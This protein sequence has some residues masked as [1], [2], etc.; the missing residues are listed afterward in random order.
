MTAIG[1]WGFSGHEF[2][3]DELVHAALLM[4][5]HALSLSELKRWRISAGKFLGRHAAI[6]TCLTS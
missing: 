3:E 6:H 5:Q 4:L 1:S 2:S